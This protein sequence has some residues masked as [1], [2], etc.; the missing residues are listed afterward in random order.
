MTGRE[1]LGCALM[2]TA[3]ILTQ[4]PDKKEREIKR[5]A[6]VEKIS[7]GETTDDQ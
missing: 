4:L 2:F 7:L 6:K 5:L 1:L 3:V